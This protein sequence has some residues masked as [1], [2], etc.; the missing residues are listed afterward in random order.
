[1]KKKKFS[2]KFEDFCM[3]IIPHTPYKAQIGQ[4]SNL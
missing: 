4:N 3:K 1:M 2:L